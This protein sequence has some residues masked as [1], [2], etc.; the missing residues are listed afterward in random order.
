[1]TRGLLNLI[2]AL[3]I[4]L[5]LMAALMIA[6]QRCDSTARFERDQAEAAAA[7]DHYVRFR[8]EPSLRRYDAAQRRMLGELNKPVTGLTTQRSSTQHAD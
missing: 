8:D 5:A 1:M 6:M 2:L 7:L 4:P 3:A